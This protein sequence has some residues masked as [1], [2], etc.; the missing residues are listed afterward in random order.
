MDLSQGIAIAALIY[1]LHKVRSTQLASSDLRLIVALAAFAW[2]NAI[3]LRTLHHYAL[4]AYTL[5]S[6]IASTLTQ[7]CLTIFWT[8]LALTAMVWSNHASRRTAWI[9]GASLLGVVTAKLFLID[10]SRT[11]TVPRIVSF[12]GVGFL[13]LVIGYYSPLPPRNR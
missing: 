5:D 8:V 7:T 3:L 12:L 10:L 2:L 4:V 6:F 1:A 9:A 13:M 11:G